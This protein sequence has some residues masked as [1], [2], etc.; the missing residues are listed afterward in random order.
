MLNEFCLFDG[1]VSSDKIQNMVRMEKHIDITYKIKW[2]YLRQS[3]FVD[4]FEAIY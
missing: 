2:N 4:F 3:C 1:L